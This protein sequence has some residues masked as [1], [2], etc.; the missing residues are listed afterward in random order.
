[1]PIHCKKNLKNFCIVDEKFFHYYTKASSPLG[2]VSIGFYLHFVKFSFHFYFIM[3]VDSQSVF[4]NR[5][6]EDGDGEGFPLSMSAYGV[7]IDEA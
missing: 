6:R 2:F 3:I 4:M 5:V 1:M 7:G